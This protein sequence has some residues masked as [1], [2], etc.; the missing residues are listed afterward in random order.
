MTP[1]ERINKI[2]LLLMDISKT[3]AR[4]EA[5]NIAVQEIVQK[6]KDFFGSPFKSLQEVKAHAESEIG[7]LLLEERRR[8]S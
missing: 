8:N 1:E 3:S 7:K 4:A 5:A 2:D 6:S